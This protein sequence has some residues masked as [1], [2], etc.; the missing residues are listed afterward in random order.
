MHLM[1][2]KTD[3]SVMRRD[4]LRELAV[5]VDVFTQMEGVSVYFLTHCHTDHMYGLHSLWFEQSMEITLF[6][7]PISK[8]ILEARLGLSHER[9]VALDLN[10]VHSIPLRRGKERF[11]VTLLD[12]NHCPGAVMFLFQ[13]TFGT[14]L[15]TGD[16]RYTPCMLE[17]VLSSVSVDV[18]YLDDTYARN[19]FEIMSREQAQKQVIQLIEQHRDH[20]VFLGMDNLG[21]E[22]LL[23]S[24]AIAFSTKVIV[25]EQRLQEMKVIFEKT[26][27][28]YSDFFATH[29]DRAFIFVV[30]KQELTQSF[31]ETEHNLNPP[32]LGICPSA[33]NA[34]AF[35]R[36]QTE[37]KSRSEN[38]LMS[39]T[40]LT[41]PY[42][43]HSGFSELK[44]FVLR[45]RP[46]TII[47]I[48]S[49]DELLF[50][51]IFSSQLNL[52]S[53]AKRFI[54]PEYRLVPRKKRTLS[55]VHD[56]P[57]GSSLVD[58]LFNDSYDT[59][60]SMLHQL[61]EEEQRMLQDSLSRHRTKN[62]SLFD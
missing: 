20:R 60:V 5:A 58:S 34:S 26:S 2:P 56:S 46:K 61:S 6:C 30:S 1:Y 23:I 29:Y 15:H 18:L 53:P 14:V 21:K 40:I 41:V 57:V 27:V 16:F 48:V 62:V 38:D 51:H 43:L 42:S 36:A 22:E 59:A 52:V 12:A 33:W 9:L 24:L 7:S 44:E 8:C 32:V 55:F 31:I 37:R 17:G 28:N 50:H 19:S 11:Q 10:K 39:G 4:P 13:G 45:L 3:P 25:S 49:S 35:L 54:H 47:P